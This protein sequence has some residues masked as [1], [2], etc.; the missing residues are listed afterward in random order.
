[1]PREQ[2]GPVLGKQRSPL[3]GGYRPPS[4]GVWTGVTRAVG[5]DDSTVGSI[6][7]DVPMGSTK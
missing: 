4:T 5:L 6:V 3:A 7:K 1:M 2:G